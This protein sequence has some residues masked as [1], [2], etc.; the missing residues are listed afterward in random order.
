[1]SVEERIVELITPLL[2]D[3]DVELIDAEYAGGRLLV[4]IDTAGG[5]DTETLTLA[6][7]VLSRELDEVDPISGKYTLEVSSPG[8]ERRLRKPEHYQ[9][10]IGDDVTVKFRGD[11]GVSK[12]VQ[13]KLL[14]AD[15]TSFVMLDESAAEVTVHFDTVLK[16]R[17]VFEWGGQP[18]PGGPKKTKPKNTDK[19]GTA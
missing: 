10:V 14:S 1:M 4:T 17:T 3:L 7:R 5:L 15:S 19:A 13:G 18:K 8:L 11:D 9:S 6:T 2:D 16:A 12:R